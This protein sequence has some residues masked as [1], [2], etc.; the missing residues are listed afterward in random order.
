MRLNTDTLHLKIEHYEKFYIAKFNTGYFL[1][2]GNWTCVILANSN[3]NVFFTLLTGIHICVE[4]CNDS[5]D[6]HVSS[7]QNISLVIGELCFI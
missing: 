6:S 5:S 4:P 7:Y 2:T 3:G 1:P